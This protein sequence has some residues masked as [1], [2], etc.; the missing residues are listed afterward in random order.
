MYL[1]FKVGAHK[2]QYLFKLTIEK[3]SAAENEVVG[4]VWVRFLT[5]GVVDHVP[6]HLGRHQVPLTVR[7]VVAQVGA[8]SRVDKVNLE[9]VIRPAKM[10]L[11][12][13]INFL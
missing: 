2:K 3:R 4:D 10:S 7:H 12:N 1:K 8:V 9:S 5:A 13:T 11:I 6:L